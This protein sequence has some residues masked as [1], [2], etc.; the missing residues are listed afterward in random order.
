M[1]TDIVNY[2]KNSKIKEAIAAIT[3][4]LDVTSL[5]DMMINAKFPDI[6]E[7]RISFPPYDLFLVISL[8]SISRGDYEPQNMLFIMFNFYKRFLET[9]QDSGLVSVYLNDKYKPSTMEQSTS[10]AISIIR[11]R[12]MYIT[13]LLCILYQQMP[14][15]PLFS[16]FLSTYFP[17]DDVESHAFKGD[18]LFYSI[19]GRICLA[20]GDKFKA[21]EFF[22]YVNKKVLKDSNQAFIDFFSCNFK[23]AEEVFKKNNNPISQINLASTLLYLGDIEGSYQVMISFLP[24]PSQQSTGSKDE[25]LRKMFGRSSVY[26]ENLKLIFELAV[27]DANIADSP[28]RRTLRYKIV[29]TISSIR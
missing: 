5:F 28:I 10:S 20:A 18:D 8:L 17:P 12:L 22:G 4:L 21:D 24:K 7:K 15:N 26:N 11:E 14:P 13:E 3:E 25:K 2:F 1:E 6:C 27:V 16:S 29:Y 19:I 23:S 9:V